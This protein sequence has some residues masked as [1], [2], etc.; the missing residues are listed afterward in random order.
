MIASRDMSRLKKPMSGLQ[1][2]SYPN[3]PTQLARLSLF[4]DKIAINPS[5]KSEE[6]SLHQVPAVM[7]NV[8]WFAMIGTARQLLAP[9]QSSG[10]HSTEAISVIHDVPTTT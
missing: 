6:T 7:F 1:H 10:V 9:V 8:P 3:H 4:D 5:K 2:P